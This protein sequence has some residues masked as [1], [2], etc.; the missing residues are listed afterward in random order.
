M[1]V[2]IG[3]NLLVVK[4]YK[5]ATRYSSGRLGDE[6]VDNMESHWCLYSLGSTENDLVLYVAT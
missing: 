2:E 4:S 1:A 3:T 6:V 5:V